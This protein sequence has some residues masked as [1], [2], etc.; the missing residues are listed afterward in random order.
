[1]ASDPQGSLSSRIVRRVQR[2]VGGDPEVIAAD[3]PGLTPEIAPEKTTLAD[4]P[5][6]RQFAKAQKLN[7]Q[8]YGDAFDQSRRIRYRDYQRIYDRTPEAKQIVRLIV[9]LVFGGDPT[10]DRGESAS[11]RAPFQIVYGE[12]IAP[13]TAAALD[14]VRGAVP[15]MTLIPQMFQSG[16]IKG[17]AF[18]EVVA[19]LTRAV[20][21]RALLA[22]NVDVVPDAFG[23]PKAYK[24]QAS[25]ST[26][27]A[28]KYLNPLFCVHYAPNRAFGHL[29]GESLFHALRGA[30]K[31]FNTAV[32]VLHVLLLLQGA[33]RRT[34]AVQVPRGWTD[35][36]IKRH[37]RKLKAWNADVTFFDSSGELHQNVAELID[38]ED[39]LIPYR[40]GDKPPQFHNDVS[41]DFSKLLDV[42]KFDRSRYYTG[43]GIPMAL[44]G[45]LDDAHSR[46]A[47]E[48]QGI[49]LGKMLRFWQQ[50][51][52]L[53]TLEFLV[54]G[55]LIAQVPLAQG[56]VEVR[57]NSVSEFD[58][59]AKAEVLK[60]RA[61]AA[62]TLRQAGVPMRWV[63][64]HVLRVAPVDV[65][66][67][68]LA[69]QIDPGQDAQ[70]E[71]PDPR[72][73]ADVM[74]ALG[75]QVER[76]REAIG[77]IRPVV[78]TLEDLAI[79][80]QRGRTP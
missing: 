71:S 47:L 40:D 45:L 17:D 46:A 63:L 80:Q 68:L 39:K 14:A 27:S 52:A 18:A 6:L 56:D 34:V 38:Y 9:A 8:L 19:S 29:Y 66:D 30:D 11:D 4:T 15:L 76:A 57:M 37:L 75:E 67:L 61:D 79:V 69:M 58:E 64:Q 12:G 62:A 5:E 49:Y 77:Q 23:T 44:A 36:S 10:T 16:Q 54:R 48:T 33:Q 42:V 22:D 2:Y 35:I 21:V 78:A 7:K 73:A 53:L 59:A 55:A 26:R 60:L 70:A 74:R 1:M 43:T 31:Q 28:A 41:P 65:D 25:S 13:E 72:A 20:G 51:A 50:D 32:D 3:L 24:V